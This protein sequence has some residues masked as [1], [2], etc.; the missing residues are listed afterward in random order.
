[1]GALGVVEPQCAG[2]RFEHLIGH[3]GGVAALQPLVVLD[4]D[5]GQR[6]DLFAAQAL[7]ASWPEGRQTGLLRRDPRPARGQE[8]GDVLGG[9]HTLKLPVSRTVKGALSLP[10]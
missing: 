4:A 7:D 5:A 6:G 8:L 3:S 1:V 2:Q 10:L 9:I